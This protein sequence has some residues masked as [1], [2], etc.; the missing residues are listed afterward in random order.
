MTDAAQV[1]KTKLRKK[2]PTSMEDPEEKGRTFQGKVKKIVREGL[3]K[4]GDK[5]NASSFS[6]I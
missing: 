2:P 5:K 3:K 4:M 6:A 1:V